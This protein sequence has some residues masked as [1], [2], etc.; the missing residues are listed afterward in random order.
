MNMYAQQ[1]E[2]AEITFLVSADFLSIDSNHISDEFAD[3]YKEYFISVEKGD[4]TMT[5]S[6]ML[7][8]FL[9]EEFL[10]DLQKQDYSGDDVVVYKYVNGV[11]EK[12]EPIA[13]HWGDLRQLG[14]VKD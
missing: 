1:T 9:L 8:E 12:R 4:V 14:L 2:P 5:V 13:W 7:P 11:C 6:Y 3:K 10:L